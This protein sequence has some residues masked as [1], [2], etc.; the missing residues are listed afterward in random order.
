MDLL[1][2]CKEVRGVPV[3]GRQTGP[4]CQSAMGVAAAGPCG[5]ACLNGFDS[6]CPERDLSQWMIRF[7]TGMRASQAAAQAAEAQSSH[8]SHLNTQTPDKQA[9]HRDVMV[10]SNRMLP[11]HHC[12]VRAPR[13]K[14]KQRLEPARCGDCTLQFLFPQGSRFLPFP[15]SNARV[16]VGRTVMEG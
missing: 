9:R 2:V 8:L 6:L 1:R 5:T 14:N 3:A 7:P 15:F 13:G 11:S 12:G 16:E 4:E 10:V